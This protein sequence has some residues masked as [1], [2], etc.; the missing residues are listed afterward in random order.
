[1]PMLH[2]SVHAAMHHLLTLKSACEAVVL[3]HHLHVVLKLV[4]TSWQLKRGWLRYK[5]SQPAYAC[6]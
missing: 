3:A 2:A 1:M 4:L 6:W 5:A